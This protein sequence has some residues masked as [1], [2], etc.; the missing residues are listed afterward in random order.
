MSTN[1]MNIE[2]NGKPHPVAVGLRVKALI[3]SLDMAEQRLAVEVNQ[4]IVP[5][6]EH[7]QFRLSAGDQVEIVRAIGGGQWPMLR[8]K[9]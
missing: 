3:E 9:D 7:G 6:S 5:R 8:Q 4:E 1:E 2:L